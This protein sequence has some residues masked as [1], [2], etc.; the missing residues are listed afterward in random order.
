MR[1]LLKNPWTWAF[2]ALFAAGVAVASPWDIDMIDGH[3][4]KAFEWKMRPPKA[5]GTIQRPGGAVSRARPHGYYQN[6]YVAPIDRNA[7]STDLLASPY[8]DTPE[9]VAIGQRLFRVNCAP[10]HGLEGKGD[11]P[12]TRNADGRRYAMAAPT[13]SGSTTRLARMS[14]GF[15]YSMIRYGGLAGMPAYAVGLTENERWAIVSYIRTLDN[16]GR[17]APVAPA[18]A[19][20]AAPADAATPTPA[21]GSSK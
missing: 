17:P 16:A 4:F 7:P 18:P 9:Q 13:L 2:G 1:E 11:G 3:S 12:V 5:E 14:D 10:C 19:E 6:D 15:I 21:N 20:G 8:G